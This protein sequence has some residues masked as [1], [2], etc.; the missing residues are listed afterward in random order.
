MLPGL[1]RHGGEHLVTQA[2]L[3]HEKVIS[4][5]GPDHIPVS[6]LTLNCSPSPFPLPIRNYWYLLAVSD[7]DSLSRSCHGPC[8][9]FPDGDRRVPPEMKPELLLPGWQVLSWE[10]DRK[11][12][13]PEDPDVTLSS[14]SL[15]PWVS[16]SLGLSVWWEQESYLPPLLLLLSAQTPAP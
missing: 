5:P 4:I 13:V 7:L 1:M 16:V 8:V 2:D 3:S 14:L 9:T 15:G 10:V 11:R 12:A 6:K